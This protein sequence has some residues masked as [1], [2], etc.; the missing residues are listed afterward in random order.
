[1]FGMPFTHAGME[2]IA[3]ISRYPEPELAGWM[4]AIWGILYFGVILFLAWLPMSKREGQNT[5]QIVA[6]GVQGFIAFA[7]FNPEYDDK[8]VL[9]LL[10]PAL[11]SVA[12]WGTFWLMRY[13]EKQRA[14][15]IPQDGFP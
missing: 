14:M 15:E 10:V 1:M 9:A 7:A 5:V 11:I 8:R 4:I 2:W 13:Q 3:G 6:I 12:I